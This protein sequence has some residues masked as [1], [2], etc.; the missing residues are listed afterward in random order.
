MNNFYANM[1][2]ELEDIQISQTTFKSAVTCQE[3]NSGQLPN[4]FAVS[5]V[6]LNPMR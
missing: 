2:V 4:I 1:R 3:S 6:P 5:L